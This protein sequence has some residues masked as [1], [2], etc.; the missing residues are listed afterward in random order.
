MTASTRTLPGRE[1]TT[2]RRPSAWLRAL[3]LA[4]RR[5][6]A[7]RR[8]PEPVGR[9]RDRRRPTARRSR[10]PPSRPAARTP[11]RRPS[12]A[13]G[14]HDL[15][16]RHRRASPSSRARTTAAPPPCADAL[17]AAGVARVVVGHRGPRPAGGRARASPGCGRPASR[18][19]VGV[20]ADEVGRAARALPAP[21]PHRPALRRAQAGGHASTAAP[22]RP[23]A[24]ASGSPAPRPGPTPT[25]CGPRATPSLVGAGTVRADDPASPSATPTGRDPLRV[26]LG[27]APAGRQGPPVPRARRRPRRACSTSSAAGACCRSWSR[28]GRRSPTTSTAPA[29]ST[30]TCSTSR[31]PSSAATTPAALFA[32]AG[33]ADHRRRLAR[34]HRRGRPR[35]ATT[36]ASTSTRGDRLMFTG[37]VEELGTVA[38]PR[39]AAAA[40][41]RRRPC[42]TTSSSG[43]SI[44]VNGCCLTVVDLGDGWW[45]ADVG[46]RD[47]RAARPSA[48]CQPGD[49]VNLER[50]VR[51]QRPPR[52]P[53]RAGPRRRRRRD[54]RPPRPTCGSACPTTLLPLRRREGL[55]HRRR[56][57]PHR[58]RRRSTTASPSPSSRTPP[59]S[60][61]SAARARA[62]ASTS[63][64]TSSPSTSSA[65]CAWKD[66]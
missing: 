10:A 51:L 39:R 12:A 47:A 13:A 31:P 61:R 48:T 56:R 54:R 8:S 35:W 52:R 59:R 42:S 36:S 34:P 2:D 18:S 4:A 16:G 28:A 9:L 19:S 6:R 60:P 57:Q 24:P 44:A 11:R 46:R 49:P 23:T 63:R 38:S 66:A 43:D 7:R 1:P 40:H 32:G 65:C 30:A 14:R 26:V 25:A 20:L 15:P 50:P 21:P 41:R 22:P 33:R 45:E 17:I 3:E 27:D 29:S 55:D 37:I 53:P 62:T 64:S 5:S 58:R